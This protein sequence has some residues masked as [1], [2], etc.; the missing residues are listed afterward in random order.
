MHAMILNAYKTTI[1]LC[2]EKINDADVKKITASTKL[3]QRQGDLKAEINY[4]LTGKMTILDLFKG[5]PKGNSIDSFFLFLT[6]VY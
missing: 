5:S 1:K 3:I 6:V 4:K 2:L